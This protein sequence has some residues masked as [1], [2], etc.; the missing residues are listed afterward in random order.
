MKKNYLLALLLCT[1]FSVNAQVGVGTTTPDPSSELDITSTN[2]GFLMP[3]VALTSTTDITTITGTEATSLLVY[4]TATVSDVV[5]GFYYW[6]GS[7]WVTLAG[8]SAAAWE[9]LGNAGT[10]DAT[11]FLGTTDAQDL[12][13]RTNNIEVLR[14]TQPDGSNDPKVIAGNGNNHGTINDPLYTFSN[15]NDT[16]IWSDGGDEMSL[17]AGSRE[18]LTL[19]EAAQD[20][21]IVNDRG[22]DID[23]RVESDLEPNMF[24]LN[25]ADDQIFVKAA[26]QHLGYIDPV[27]IYANSVGSATVGI[28]YAIAGWNQGNQGG[29]GNFVIEDATNG[30]AA[31]ESSTIGP[32][33]ST[34]ALNSDSNGYGVYGSIPTTGTWLGYG[35]LFTGGLA[36]MNGLYNLSDKRVKKEIQNID[37]PLNKIMNIQGVT[38]KYDMTKY[39]KD[40]PEDPRTYYGFIAQDIKK[41][42]PHA[43]AEK[44]VPFENNK[45]RISAEENKRK[46]LNVVDYTAVIPV[47]VEALKEQQ[48]IIENQNKRI[49]AL[50]KK[51]K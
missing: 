50:E 10:N 29:G 4:N 46:L 49:L 20:E 16:G 12:A 36:Y 17:G 21:L 1:L 25:A 30:Y 51:S 3:R 19:D 14:I 40:A 31:M 8:T 23:F 6:D 5:P 42:L 41:E 22:A 13:V 2:R 18:F 48:K 28:Q 24:F 37:T 9:L 32:G 43:V 27:S 45:T 39:N 38:Y 47:L 7:K 34:R 15:D 44:L 33:S 11:N 35:G 26:S